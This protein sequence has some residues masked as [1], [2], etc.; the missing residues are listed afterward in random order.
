[1]TFMVSKINIYCYIK[2]A[3][4]AISY[5]YIIDKICHDFLSTL[6]VYSCSINNT[7]NGDIIQK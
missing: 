3:Q 7:C 1:M 5:I 4:Y 6:S 2:Q